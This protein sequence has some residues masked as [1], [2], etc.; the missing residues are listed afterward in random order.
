MDVDV[1]DALSSL[2]A[3]LNGIVHSGAPKLVPGKE[4]EE[5]QRRE[6]EESKEKARKKRGKAAIWLK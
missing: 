4:G 1:R 5:K 6:S 3:V 2:W